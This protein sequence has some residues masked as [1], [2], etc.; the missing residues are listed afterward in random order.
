[1]NDLT[2]R[3]FGTLKVINRVENSKSGKA[4]WLCKCTICGKESRVVGSNLLS[5]RTKTCTCQRNHKDLVGMVFGKLTVIEYIWN[6]GWK[7][8]CKCS[9]GNEHIV[10][11]EKLTSGHTKSCGH[12]NHVGEEINGIKLI[13]QLTKAKYKC[14]CPYC[15]KEFESL[16]SR[17]T[18]G[19]IKSCGCQSKKLKDLTGVRFGKLTVINKAYMKDGQ[20]VWHCRCDCGN[21]TDVK[22]QSLRE[23]LT[24]SCGCLSINFSGS[25]LENEIKDYL[26]KLTGL[27]AKKE[28]VLS[29][30]EID[31]YFESLKLGIEFNGSAFHAT[32]NG[33]YTNKEKDYHLNKFLSAKEKG[34]RLI[35]IFDVDYIENKDKILMWLKEL[36]TQKKVIYARKCVCTKIDKYK[37]AE[38]CNKY[39]LQGHTRASTINYGLYYDDELVSVMTFGNLRMHSKDNNFELY[40]Y[41]VK[42]GYTV[43][44]G[45]NKLLSAFER[46]YNPN[47]LVSYSNNNY[48]TG[49]IYSKLGFKY[50]KQCSISYFWV[51]NGVKYTREKCQPRLLKT[52]YIDLYNK[53]KELN[54]GVE[55]YVMINLGAYKV[56]ECGNTRWV[57]YAKS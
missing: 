9:C 50:D 19:H 17:L 47:M 42:S 5:G 7:W 32:E 41:V 24:R 14:I 27:K 2:G 23:G 30:K 51:L 55:N 22:G 15:G 10:K 35:T 21:Y 39:H 34:I 8:K 11:T 13:E 56:Y 28:K 25:R 52:K 6:S 44:G 18:S 54:V 12:C 53:A 16:Y 38:F 45:A 3:Q 29:G 26:E 43:I 36:V 40:R 4:M 31:I 20:A 37:T 49:N 57:K 1:M 48:F 33:V 46:E